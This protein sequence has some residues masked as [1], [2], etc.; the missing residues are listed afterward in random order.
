MSNTQEIVLEISFKCE[1]YFKERLHTILQIGSSI[2]A[3]K[4]IND[5]D[6]IIILKIKEQLDDLLE[7]RKILRLYEDFTFD[8]QVINLSDINNQTFSHFSHGIFFAK[9]LAEANTIFGDNPFCDLKIDKKLVLV[10]VI[11]KIQYYYFRAKAFILEN[12]YLNDLNQ[13][14]Y[15]YHKKKILLMLIDYWLAKNNEVLSLKSSSDILMI[16]KT[17]NLKDIDILNFLT[18]D[19]RPYKFEDIFI[20]YDKVYKM[21]MCDLNEKLMNISTN[22]IL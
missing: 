1:S 15:S 7:V 8:V 9:F 11:Q 10:S 13:K 5:I 14:D 2:N 6:L 19:Y 17:L 20:I 4:D 16:M 22:L 21:I 3:E 18:S 12:K